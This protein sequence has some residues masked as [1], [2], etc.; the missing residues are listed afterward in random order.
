MQ[1]TGLALQP[2]MVRHRNLDA[3]WFGFRE[4]PLTSLFNWVMVQAVL[5]YQ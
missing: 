4:V 3:A 2:K 1:K 5:S